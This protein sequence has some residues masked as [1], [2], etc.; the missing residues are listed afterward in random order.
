MKAVVNVASTVRYFST[1]IH[2]AE[3]EMD[4]FAAEMGASWHT[5]KSSRRWP[6]TDR[7]VLDVFLRKRSSLRRSN[8]GGMVPRSLLHGVLACLLV[9]SLVAIAVPASGRPPPRPFCDACGDAF[10]REAAYQGVAVTVTRSN[11]T[12]QV[13]GNGSATWT[14]RNH[15]VDANAT[16][17]LRE[18]ASLRQR[19]SDRTMDGDLL[20]ATVSDAGVL[21]MRSRERAF[22]EQSVGGT[23]RSGAFT[24]AYG[25]RNLDGLGADRLVVVAPR[26]MQIG[27]KVPNATVSADGRRMTLTR[28]QRE[29]FVTFVP[30]ESTLAPVASL[31][32]IVLL[33]TP[34]LLTNLLVRVAFPTVLFGLGVAALDTA[35]ARIDDAL[36]IVRDYPGTV[37]GVSGLVLTVGAL[38]LGGGFRLL[39]GSGAPAFGAG[40]TFVVF[41]VTLSRRSPRDRVDRQFLFASAVVG[42]VLAAAI[43]AVG[44]LAFHQNNLTHS[45]LESFSALVP[46]FALL[47][48]GYALG[49][50]NRRRAV[51]LVAGGFV[52]GTLWTTSFAALITPQHSQGVLT[53]FVLAFVVASVTVV[54]TPLL[55]VGRA[56]AN[57]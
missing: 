30:R 22:A 6:T 23:L 56:L 25:Y 46:I 27:S 24:E 9:C 45:L 36:D 26:G 12:I 15:L 11:A 40:L 44:A 35:L 37:L 13:H 33:V 3:I 8:T 53:V 14:V 32:A 52:L 2:G 18:N 7:T 47:P 10:E 51:A 16:A 39:G 55:V 49:E 19:I 50:E 1:V 17:R 42:A 21:T 20:G 4:E 54:G 43:T 5:S 41:G 34:A 28:F 48:A 31:L 38:A 29:G 57:R